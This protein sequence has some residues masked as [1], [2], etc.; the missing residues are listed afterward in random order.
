MNDYVVISNSL[1]YDPALDSRVDSEVADIDAA[2]GEAYGPLK[3]GSLYDFRLVVTPWFEVILEYGFQLPFTV[4][5]SGSPQPELQ[6][7]S[8]TGGTGQEG[9]LRFCFP[10]GCIPSGFT[11]TD[12]TQDQIAAGIKS[13]L[14]Q[15]AVSEM[16][17]VTVTASSD[18]GTEHFDIVIDGS[19]G[20]IPQL[21]VD[22]SE[23]S[24]AGTWT[25]STI[26]DGGP[27]LVQQTLS[28]APYVEDGTLFTLSYEG[29][30]S[31]VIE[32]GATTTLELEGIIEAIPGINSILL[33][34]LDDTI[35][36]GMDIPILFVDPGAPNE[37][38]EV[39][40]IQ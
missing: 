37:L 27:S 25:W 12:L 21:S 24:G 2:A 6:R 23:T 11:I 26:Q 32:V 10:A 8:T 39:N 20:N 17:D 31:A 16:Y 29:N 13:F 19:A 22:D 35:I 38:L 4:T 5:A 40:E 1:A 7:I 34:P 33:D 36:P 3:P 9:T 18:N 30:T 28:I 15:Y 14:D